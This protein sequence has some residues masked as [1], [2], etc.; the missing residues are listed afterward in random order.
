ML[1]HKNILYIETK[2]LE[3]AGKSNEHIRKAVSTKVKAIAA[4]KLPDLGVSNYFKW[5]DMT[6]GW[7]ECI[8]KRF[9]NP[10]DYVAR[11]PIM[12]MIVQDAKAEAFYLD[13]RYDQKALPIKTVRKYTRAA[14][15]LNMLKDVQKNRQFI[16]KTLCL[17]IPQFY[18]N[19]SELI[20]AEKANG[21][22]EK[23]L[24]NEQLSGDFPATYQRLMNRVSEY[25][26]K[27]YSYLIDA[28]YGNQL[29]AKVVDEVSESLLLEM[30]C[31]QNQ[32]DDYIICN[33]YN[34]WA[35]AN[36]RKTI[37]PQTVGNKRRENEALIIMS[38]EGNAALHGKYLRQVNFAVTNID[39]SKNFFE[40]GRVS[41]NAD[42]PVFG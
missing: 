20:K 27:G 17:T 40:N 16:K 37:S 18:E 1:F 14:C 15:W 33:Q 30:L 41:A 13:Y 11:E 23:Y 35:K 2:D 21:K 39:R 7:R 5:D 34:K 25:Q 29:A 38:R 6:N 26:E 32:F 9:G 24:G 10:Y 4:C 22:N 19:C 3:T 12:K 28:M 8:E 42:K 31:H 36:D